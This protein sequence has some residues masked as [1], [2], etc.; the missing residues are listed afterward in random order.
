[1]LPVPVVLV[2]VLPEPN[3]EGPWGVDDGVADDVE[4]FVAPTFPNRP[5]PLDPDVFC[6]DPKG[7]A[8]LEDPK[9]PEEGAPDDAGLPNIALQKH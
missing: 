1:M 8:G 5:P 6:V 4:V 7:L 3:I 9:S 2:V